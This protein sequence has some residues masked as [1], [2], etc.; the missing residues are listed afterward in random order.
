ME[1]N[2]CYMYISNNNVSSHNGSHI[3]ELPC[4]P[5]EVSDSISVNW[6]DVSII[7]RTPIVAYNNTGL[8]N[9]S[10]SMDLHLEMFY[11]YSGSYSGSAES[12]PIQNSSYRI[13]NILKALRSSV[14]P[15]YSS[16][17]LKP[18]MVI[19]CFGE[20]MMKGIIRSVGFQWKKP[21]ID[22]CYSLCTVSITMDE[23]A[24]PGKGE[25]DAINNAYNP[26]NLTSNSTAEWIEVK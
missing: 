26:N 4:Y 23:L 6:S 24:S 18:P 20:L 1:S 9:I 10:F 25:G 2:E 16:S 3:Y 17:G 12:S 7:G 13:K 19:F 5:D 14:Y 15:I 8:R 11:G 22:K 21:I